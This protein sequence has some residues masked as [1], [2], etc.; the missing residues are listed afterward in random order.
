MR[1]SKRW[2]FFCVATSLAATAGAQSSP[3][4][5]AS[6][7]QTQSSA[8]RPAVRALPDAARAAIDSIPDEG[9]QTPRMHYAVSNEWGFQVLAEPLRGLGGVYVGVGSDQNYTMAAMARA[10]LLLLVDYDPVIPY[11]HRMYEK[12]VVASETPEALIARFDEDQLGPTTELLRTSLA[13][14]P[15]AERIVTMY[16]N[17]RRWVSRYLRRHVPYGRRGGI[18][19]LT[20]RGHYDYVREMFRAGRIVARNGDVTGERTM[21]AVGDA[22]RRAGL[23]VRIVYFSNAEQFFRYTPAFRRNMESLPTDDRSVVVRTIRNRQLDYPTRDTWHYVVH[24]MGDFV[25]RL[26]TGAYANVIHLTPD[27]LAER[28]RG[29]STGVAGLSL[30]TRSTP[31]LRVRRRADA[32]AAP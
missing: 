4:S 32:P 2:V 11:V 13:G 17:H 22:A 12:L 27:V 10:E 26:Q 28:R 23:P 31:R 25:E 19:W 7:P 16:R 1:S 9:T 30:M 5:P 21:R 24:Q 29:V 6:Q 20:D 3:D 15:L 14:D 18:T 8:Q